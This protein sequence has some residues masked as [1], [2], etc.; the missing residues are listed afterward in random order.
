[1]TLRALVLGSC[2]HCTPLS[3]AAAHLAP[4]QFSTGEMQAVEAW[5]VLFGKE[6]VRRAVIR[7]RLGSARAGACLKHPNA[8]QTVPDLPAT[9]A[10]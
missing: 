10:M 6:V 4:D 3:S 9:L 8:R 7:A 2:R 1:M 5:L